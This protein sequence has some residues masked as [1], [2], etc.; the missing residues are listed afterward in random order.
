MTAAATTAA[1]SGEGSRR[2]RPEARPGQA[3]ATLGSQGL[4]QR[5]D[6]GP[7]Q[8]LGQDQDRV[9]GLDLRLRSVPDRDQFPGP[10][11]DP[12]PGHRPPDAQNRAADQ[13]QFR[14]R[15]LVRGQALQPLAVPDPVRPD[16][17][18]VLGQARVGRGLVLL[19]EKEA[20]RINLIF[21]S[22]VSF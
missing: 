20:N 19:P 11:R 12:G 18:L 21:V 7:G 15:A 4:A 14:D 10:V 2:R 6:R 9:Q 8:A 1:A 3:A 5:R 13:D 16:P 22:F 17:G